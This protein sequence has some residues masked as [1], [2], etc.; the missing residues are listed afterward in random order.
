MLALRQA[1]G[2]PELSKSR[3]ASPRTPSIYIRSR[4][5]T[6]ASSI[7]H[8]ALNPSD[9][10]IQFVHELSAAGLAVGADERLV[11]THH[12]IRPGVEPLPH[13]FPHIPKVAQDCI[14]V[15]HLVGG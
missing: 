14:R 7:A 6:H 3:G 15:V 11:V 5:A 8:L 13:L 12:I 9:D 2:D 4:P 1:Q 10:A